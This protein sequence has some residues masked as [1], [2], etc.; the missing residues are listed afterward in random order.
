MVKF[1]LEE[2]TLSAFGFSKRIT[3][4]IMWGLSNSSL[5]LLWKGSKLPPISPTRGL[6]QGDL[7]SP[8][9]LILCMKR[10]TLCINELNNE[11]G[12]GP[13]L[14]HLLFVDDILIFCKT[15]DLQA[16]VAVS[17]LEEFALA[18]NLKVNLAKSRFICLKRISN[19]RIELRTF[20]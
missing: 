16:R 15:L 12:G 4:L 17:V 2:N 20:K 1:D 18:S 5:S 19:K 14:S 6:R 9:P 11:V 8:Y 10:L 7:L 3:R 13:L